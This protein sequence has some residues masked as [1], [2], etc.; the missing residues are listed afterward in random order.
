[1][2]AFTPA[3][4]EGSGPLHPRVARRAGA[5]LIIACL[6]F[7]GLLVRILLYQTVGYDKYQQKVIEQMTTE[8]GVNAD[9]GNIYDRN[10]VLLATNVSTYRIF[11][12]PSTIASAQREMNKNGDIGIPV[13]DY[14]DE[15]VSSKVVK[16]IQSYTSVVNKMVWRK[17]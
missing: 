12:S 5:L 14:L 7:F 1:M 16:I 17:E 11:I 10:G 8:S 4:E 9:R 3:P 2:R 6:L 15:T 13:P